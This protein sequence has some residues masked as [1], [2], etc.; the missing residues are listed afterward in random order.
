[1]QPLIVTA[2]LLRK[3]HQILITKRPA[4]KQQGGFWEFPGGKLNSD[5]TPQQALHREL[6]EEIDLEV[7]VGAIFEV[8]Y[9]RYDWGPVL[10]LVYECHPLSDTIRNLEVDEHRWITVGQLPDFDL[11]PADRPIVDKLLH[12]GERTRSSATEINLPTAR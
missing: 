7:E 4:D 8:V 3:D 9:H 1:M 6:L 11:L 12:Q 5:E 2:A 10:I